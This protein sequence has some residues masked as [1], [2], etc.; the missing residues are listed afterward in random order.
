VKEVNNYID[1]SYIIVFVG[2]AVLMLLSCGSEINQ[3]TQIQTEPVEICIHG[4]T[5]YERTQGLAI[6]LTEEGKPVSC[7][8]VVE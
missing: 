8:E 6:R 2:T 5:Y 4:H 7:P 1:M 3:S